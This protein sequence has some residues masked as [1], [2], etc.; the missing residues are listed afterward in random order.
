MDENNNIITNTTIDNKKIIKECRNLSEHF[1]NCMEKHKYTKN[2][3]TNC[4]KEFYY[5]MNCI[6]KIK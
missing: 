3:A 4:G 5:T 6:N 1:W 2:V